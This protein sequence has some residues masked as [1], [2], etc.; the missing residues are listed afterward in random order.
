MAKRGKIAA[1]AQ[2]KCPRCHEGDMFKTPITGGKIYDMYENCTEC[3]QLFE[4]EPGF[5]WGAMYIGYGLSGGYMLTVVTALIVGLGWSTEAAF[6]VAILGGVVILPVIA[7]LAR[8]IWIHIYV[9]YDPEWKEKLN[10]RN[11][12]N[13]KTAVHNH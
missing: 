1:I 8:S 11:Q 12:K 6:L 5:Y 7:R 4:I 2:N 3:G 13:V 10:N 9:G